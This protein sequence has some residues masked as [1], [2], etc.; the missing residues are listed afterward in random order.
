MAIEEQRVGHEESHLLLLSL[1]VRSD[2]VQITSFSRPWTLKT[3]L[4]V[5]FPGCTAD[6]CIPIRDQSFSTAESRTLDICKP[7]QKLLA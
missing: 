5:S 1:R 6:H 7:S 2:D 4:M 3:T